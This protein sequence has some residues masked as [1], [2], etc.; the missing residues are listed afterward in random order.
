MPPSPA[1]HLAVVLN[2][3]PVSGLNLQQKGLQRA[4]MALGVRGV[5]TQRLGLTRFLARGLGKAGLIRPLNRVG[6]TRC[7]VNVTWA[8][9]ATLFPAAY[10][11]EVVPWVYDCWGPQFGAWERLFRK[12][13]V[14]EVCF[15]AR[16]AAGHF[17]KAM[18][19]LQTHWVPEACDPSLYFPGKPLAER[20]THVLELGR[21]SAELHE[22]ITGPLRA[23]GLEHVFST[24][25]SEKP[26]FDGLE[27][28]Y[29]AMGDTAV[30]MCFP[31]SV[32]NPAGAGGVETVTQRYF[33]TMGSGALAVG[34]CPAELKDL[35][36][37]DPVIALSKSDPGGQLVNLVKTAAAYQGHVDKCRA[38]LLEV[39]TC[40]ARAR[41]MLEMIGTS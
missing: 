14:R 39:G 9:E 28:L 15:T 10:F 16:D 38:R 19:G 5:H 27:A 17:A 7:L 8:S 35:F 21:K 34:V 12:F 24:G 23:A 1:E 40:E 6:N 22:A 13:R 20:G 30:S 41:A 18:P 33:E 11:R 2:D 36:G 32:T 25:G 4:L 31:K 26:I 29:R 3:E 37:F